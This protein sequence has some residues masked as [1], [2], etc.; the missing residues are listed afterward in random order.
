MFC[1][2]NVFTILKS[3]GVEFC[4]IFQHIMCLVLW[5]LIRDSSNG[6]WVIFDKPLKDCIYIFSITSGTSV[7]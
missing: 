3:E 6:S 5:V 1:V 2:G 4:W 7:V